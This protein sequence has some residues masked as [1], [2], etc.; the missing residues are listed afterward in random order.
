VLAAVSRLLFVVV[1]RPRPNRRGKPRCP[2]RGY[3]YIPNHAR[4]LTFA[5]Q[6]RQIISADIV[7]SPPPADWPFSPTAPLAT[8]D[9][10]GSPVWKK[11]NLLGGLSFSG[12]ATSTSQRHLHPPYHSCSRGT[13]TSIQMYQKSTLQHAVASGSMLVTTAMLQIRSSLQNTQ[14]SR[15][16][17]AISL[18]NSA[19]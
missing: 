15:F 18:S 14:S 5:Q 17:R 2:S 6:E 11:S 10:Y 12:F 1:R 9:P 13:S 4:R 19:E 16:C 3:S 8:R 7:F